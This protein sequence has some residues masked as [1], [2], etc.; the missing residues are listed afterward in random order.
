MSLRRSRK[1]TH[2]VRILLGIIMLPPAVQDFLDISLD[3]DFD[4]LN[5]YQA[6][7]R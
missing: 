6:D 5:G 2:Q 4:D 7:T 1:E 3:P